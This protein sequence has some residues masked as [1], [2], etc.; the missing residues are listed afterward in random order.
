MEDMKLRL[1][2]KQADKITREF[3]RTFYLASLFL[4]PEKKHA[5][6]A[7]YAICRLSDEAVDSGD[8]AGREN[9]LKKL[10]EKISGAYSGG[11]TE[12]PLLTAF[13]HTLKR[14]QIPKEYFDALIRGMRMDL[15]FKRYPDFPSLSGYCYNVAGV[16]GLIMLK[17]FGYKDIRAE[18]YAVKLGIAMQLTN[19]LRDI[20]EDLG[21]GRIY[22][23]QDEISRFGISEKQ[24][25]EGKLDDNFRQ[26]MRFQI[27]RCRAFY[28]ESLE[29][30]K[31]IENPICRFAVLCMGEIYS[32]ILEDIEKNGYD[33][34]SRRARTG[35]LGKIL[36][37]LK[38]TIQ[39]KY[40]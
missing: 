19:I 21:R 23:P 8:G 30:V 37:I 4:P 7:V 12:D 39:G 5:S 16:V 3:A 32:A 40:L 34:F 10:E 22:L 35:N 2:F 17:V 27:E 15:E 11:Q 6:Y 28:R 36:L 38:I 26:F 13:S 9:K 29:G 24:L 33:V 20:K 25:A 1:G 31:L 18:G 14:Y